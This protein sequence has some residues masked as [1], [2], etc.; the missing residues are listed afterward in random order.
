VADNPYKPLQEHTMLDSQRCWQAVCARDAAEDDNFVFAVRTTGIY[1]R[2]SCPARRPL[3]QN[4]TY[5]SDAAA[6][7]AAGFRACQRCVPQG[8]SPAA[9]LDELVSAACRLLQDSPEPLT[10][11]QLSARIGVSASHLTRA[12]KERTGMTPKAWSLARQQNGPTSASLPARSAKGAGLQL[13]YTI[14][15]CPLGY[16]LLAATAKGICA[17]LFGDSPASLESELAER[18]P[19][20]RRNLDQAALAPWLQQVVAQLEQPQRAAMLPLDLQG[21]AFQQRVWQALQRIPAGETRNY[22]ELAAALDSH[23]R[24]VASACARNPVGLL[25]PCHRVIGA[26]GSLSGYRWGLQRKAALLRS[27]AHK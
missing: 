22:G 8:R 25:V 1:C 9:V 16:L 21:T 12:F 19:A 10:L 17:L 2:P 27:E 14:S 3:A 15:A 7:E 13:H 18:F 23:P 26:N 20:A 6:A 11:T 4:I 24:A 5:F